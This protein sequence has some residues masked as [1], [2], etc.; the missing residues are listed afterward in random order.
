[1]VKAAK[2]LDK[3]QFKES[4]ER[5]KGIYMENNKKQILVV[6]TVSPL[7]EGLGKWTLKNNMHEI[8]Y[9]HSEEQA[10][11]LCN[12]QPFELVVLDHSGNESGFRKLY[13]VLP[14]LCE[15]VTILPYHGEAETALDKKLGELNNLRKMERMKRLLIL[16]PTAAAPEMPLAFSMN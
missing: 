12:R 4:C 6:S 14:I 10:I 8:K 16:D 15:Q 1:L 3:D 11:E 7:S 5:A 2:T 9:A 13:A